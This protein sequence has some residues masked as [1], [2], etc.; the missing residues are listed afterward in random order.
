MGKYGIGKRVRDSEGDE[1]VIVEKL[2]GERRVEYD[3]V[4]HGKI[5]WSKKSLTPIGDEPALQVVVGKFYKASNG[6]KIGPIRTQNDGN[7]CWPFRAD[8]G[9]FGTLYYKEDGECNTG[10]SG[11]DSPS[12]NLVEEWTEEDE[13]S[14][15][16]KPKFKVGDRIRNTGET[17]FGDDF[18]LGSTG[19]IVE[20]YGDGSFDIKNDDTGW[21]GFF[22][23]CEIELVKDSQLEPWEPSVGDKVRFTSA[24]PTEWWFGPHTEH[25][26]G[27]VSSEST[28]PYKFKVD[29]GGS[30]TK[31]NV[32]PKH[33]ELVKESEPTDSAPSADWEPEE[34]D[35]ARFTKDNPNGG[36]EYGVKGEVVI[37]GQLW[38]YTH[39]IYGKQIRVKRDGHSLTPLAPISALE[40][41]E[42][43]ARQKLEVGDKVRIVNNSRKDCFWLE[44][45]VGKT[46]EIEKR[47][48]QEDGWCVAGSIYWWPECDLEPVANKV[49][50]GDT[51]TLA[52][53]AT[54][55]ALNGPNASLKLAS[56]KGYDLPVD[57]LVQA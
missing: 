4:A 47:C 36:A 17:A 57:A 15:P 39:S 29:V 28:G 34:G 11:P 50:A 18:P 19:V 41:V 6:E 3:D 24:C 1:G 52:E 40:P 25:T 13:E 37:I 5:W 23:E 33:I 38:P 30:V 12:Y 43:E 31:A 9:P 44:G 46:V 2:K 22:L 26:E 48:S 10:M 32:D 20:D 54:V 14:T 56:G 51:V 42:P 53:P 8:G 7:E 21:E 27:V 49:K 45:D 35:K 55:T 16:E